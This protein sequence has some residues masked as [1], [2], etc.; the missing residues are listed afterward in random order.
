MT[1]NSAPTSGRAAVS[2][3]IADRLRSEILAGIRIPGER[4]RQ[5]LLAEDFGV[6]RLPVREALRIVESDGLVTLVANTGAWVSSLDLAECTETY[7]IRE[8]LEPLLLRHSVMNFSDE[9]IAQ[10]VDLEAQI[11]Q[12]GNVEDYLDLDRKFH[13]LSYSAA[14]MPQLASMATRMWNT[15]HHY[16]RAY[17]RL[18]GWE[19]LQM[20]HYEHKLLVEAFK[21]RD[22]DEAGRLMYGHLRRTRLELSRH[23]E[24]FE[25]AGST[26]RKK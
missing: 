12:A 23:P 20:T 2:Q 1:K 6:S 5:E 3:Q 21:H 11:E 9:L 22:A 24:L 13:R 4:I 7:L 17:T 18:I 15:T 10:L 26:N 19:G 16:R 14:Q 8:Q 25:T